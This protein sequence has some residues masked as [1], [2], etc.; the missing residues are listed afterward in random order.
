[1]END[2][3]TR[4][5][6]YPEPI[7]LS[8]ILYN[9]IILK[10]YVS[11]N[12]EKAY[13]ELYEAY[14]LFVIRTIEPASYDLAYDTVTLYLSTNYDHEESTQAIKELSELRQGVLKVSKLLGGH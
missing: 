13:L 2:I 3:E 5:V 8:H 10:E 12:P 11:N 4:F 7:Q 9:P 1:M 6:S 14:S